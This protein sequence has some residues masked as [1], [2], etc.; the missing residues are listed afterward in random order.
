MYYCAFAATYF[1]GSLLEKNEVT[2]IPEAGVGLIAGMLTSLGMSY[3]SSKAVLQQEQF[4]AEFFF[5]WL[6]PPIIFEAGYNMDS[7][8]FFASIWPTMFFAFIGTFL[9]T[10]VVGGVLW[11]AGQYGLCYPMSLLASLTF[12]SIISATDP[13]TVLAVFSALGVKVDLFSMVFGESVLNDAVAIVLSRTI[14]P[15]KTVPVTAASVSNAVGLF[16]ILFIGSTIIGMVAGVLATVTFRTLALNAHG[17]QHKFVEFALS[18]CFPWVSYFIAEWIE[19]SGIVA[20]LFCGIVMATFT[21][22]L[23]SDTAY[24]LTRDV[25]K[26]VAFLAET[27]VFVYLGMATITFPIFKATAWG[28][29]VVSMLACFLGR[30]H[31]YLGSFITNCF[32]DASSSPGPI[33]YAYMFVM[34]FSGLRGGVAFALA[35]MSYERRDFPE[36]CGGLA[37]NVECP[38]DVTDSTAL[39]QGTMVIAVFTIFIFGGAVTKVAVELDV[40]EPKAVIRPRSGSVRS[41]PTRTGKVLWSAASAKTFEQIHQRNVKEGKLSIWSYALRHSHRILVGKEDAH[42]ED[43]CSLQRQT[44]PGAARPPPPTKTATA[45][46]VEHRE[47]WPTPP[48][49]SPP[50]KTKILAMML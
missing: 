14:L 31:I 21:R 25:Y 50:M 20:I 22:R 38:F 3:S 4:D 19:L 27:F 29:V 43:S 39:L 48:S 44:L 28:L 49:H 2:W 6:L 33:S 41:A 45:N 47:S 24:L 16:F 8:A 46:G 1:I 40:L 15:F 42:A 30:M 11:C 23:M 10:F 37:A 12:G 9:S 18:F 5:R 32:R 35:A 17:D 34:W 13:V 26:S 7:G 36:R